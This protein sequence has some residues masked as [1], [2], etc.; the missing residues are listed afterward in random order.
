TGII[1][2]ARNIGASVGIATVTTML[3]RRTQAH[4][5][6]LTEHVNP[7]SLAYHRT[8]AGFTAT[9]TS[10]GSTGTEAAARASGAVYGVVERQAAMLAFLD[11]YKFLGVVFLIVL[12]VL[13]L[14]KRPKGAVNAPVH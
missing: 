2:L 3:E 10:A 11:D 5:A 4:T 14:L 1:N 6:R 9:F 7:F 12:P 8:L 13:L